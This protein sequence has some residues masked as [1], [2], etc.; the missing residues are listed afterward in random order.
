MRF[1]STNRRIGTAY[2][3]L[4]PGQRPEP[5]WHAFSSQLAE[6]LG[7]PTLSDAIAMIF[8][9]TR[10]NRDNMLAQHSVEPKDVS[11]ARRRLELQEEDDEQLEALE[12]LLPTSAGFPPIVAAATQPPIEPSE[13]ALE[14]GAGSVEPDLP[15]EAA[16][17][18]GPIVVTQVAVPDF[19]LANVIMVDARPG[20]TASATPARP[21]SGGQGVG[22][23]STAPTAAETQRNRD[24]GR[25]GE[26]IAYEREKQRLIDAGLDPAHVTWE[27]EHNELAPYD[28]SSVENGQLLHRGQINYRL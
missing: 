9:T 4:Q 27:S 16:E 7:V 12:R 8:T 14:S 23:T 10:E 21:V 1:G 17:P 6:F 25:H 18:P 15:I 26:R 24:V 2:L 13:P 19:D 28:I 5:D 3:R 20:A 11:E 22:G